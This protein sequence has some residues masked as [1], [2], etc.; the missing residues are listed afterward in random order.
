V[1][2]LLKVFAMSRTWR[3]V[4]WE[5]ERSSSTPPLPKL[6]FSMYYIGRDSDS[7]NY[8]QEP[9]SKLLGLFSFRQGARNRVPRILSESGKTD[10][11][12]AGTQLSDTAFKPRSQYRGESAQCNFSGC[13]SSGVY[14]HFG[15]SF[16]SHVIW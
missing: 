16:E 3:P 10:S 5:L 1:R 6:N 2:A 13:N 7:H 14:C 9:L 12:E 15:T 4:A 11:Q 8:S